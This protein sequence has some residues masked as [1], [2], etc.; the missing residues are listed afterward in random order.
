MRRIGLSRSRTVSPTRPVGLGLQK[1]WPTHIT[2]RVAAYEILSDPTVS[3]TISESKDYVLT[4]AENRKSKY[5][6]DMARRA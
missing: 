4:E 5:T 3:C 6:T 1:P 2:S